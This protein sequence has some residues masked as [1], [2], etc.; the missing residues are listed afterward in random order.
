MNSESVIVQN[1]DH[2]QFEIVLMNSV[3]KPITLK[4]LY[5]YSKAKEENQNILKTLRL[6]ERHGIK[7]HSKETTSSFSVNSTKETRP[8]PNLPNASYM[9]YLRSYDEKGGDANSIYCAS[10]QYNV[11]C[12]RNG[13]FHF[14]RDSNYWGLSSHIPIT[15][16]LGFN[17]LKRIG[18]KEGKGL[19]R[20][21]QGRLNPL[22]LTKKYDRSGIGKK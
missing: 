13:S 17:M 1:L 22:F 21:E 18:W 19:G 12:T 7:L 10:Y 3:H 5:S 11:T 16:G 2:N 8:L 4:T 9:D 20:K 6:L 15:S 14:T